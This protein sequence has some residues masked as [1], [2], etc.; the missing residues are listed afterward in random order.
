LPHHFPR[1]H[2]FVW[3]NESKETGWQIESSASAQAA[4]SAAISSSIYA[5]NMFAGLSATPIPPL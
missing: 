3:F 2:A 1:I 4:F 5:S